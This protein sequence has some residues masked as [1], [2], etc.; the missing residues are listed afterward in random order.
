MPVRVTN[1]TRATVLADQA[2]VATSFFARL[3]GLLGR[4]ALPPGGGLHLDPC[5]SIHT[6]FMRFPIDVVFLD[7]EC[8]VVELSLG[9]RP[10]HLAGAYPTARSALELPAG[11]V[12]ATDT[13]IGDLLTL[14][15][16]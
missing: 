8:R 16:V 10:W 14:E 15:S 9:L 1:K 7:S 5:N 13:K 6:F 11:V 3:K 4:P 2:A 12:A